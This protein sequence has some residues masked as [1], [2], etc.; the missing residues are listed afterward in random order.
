[1]TYL[2]NFASPQRIGRYGGITS[3]ALCT[4]HNCIEFLRWPDGK[5]ECIHCARDRQPA[6]QSE[7]LGYF[8]PPYWEWSPPEEKKGMI[9]EEEVERA[10]IEAF[11]AVFR[12]WKREEK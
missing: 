6:M 10:V 8:T 1:M 9:T 2:A 3:G 7:N 5:E 12:K 4:A 11:R